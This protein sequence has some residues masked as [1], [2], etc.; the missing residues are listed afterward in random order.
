MPD[1]V[2]LDAEAFLIACLVLLGAGLATTI[3]LVAH[4]RRAIGAPIASEKPGL[5]NRRLL[6]IGAQGA[7]LALVAL[8][9]ELPL[10]LVTACLTLAAA[11]TWLAPGFKDAACGETGVQRG[12]YARRFENL[13]EWRMTGEHLRFRLFGQWTSVPVPPNE[14]PRIREKLLHLNPTRESRFK[15]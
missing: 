10:P 11:I 12:W 15:D 3:A 8:R 2:P 5:R 4:A 7:V 13:E 6:L 9:G 14:Q 1:D